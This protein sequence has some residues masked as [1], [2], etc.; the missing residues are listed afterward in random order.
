MTHHREGQGGGFS[1]LMAGA[2][3]LLWGLGV[4]LGL[5]A[6][7]AAASSLWPGAQLCFDLALLSMMVT[8]GPSLVRT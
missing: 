4:A 2:I 7:I 5:L 3:G 6:A 8:R 1:R